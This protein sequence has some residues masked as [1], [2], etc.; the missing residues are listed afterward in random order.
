MCA[1]IGKIVEGESRPAALEQALR[2]E[3]PEAHMV[4]H[5]GARRKVRLT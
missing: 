4:R 5:T 2:D 3:D 1:A